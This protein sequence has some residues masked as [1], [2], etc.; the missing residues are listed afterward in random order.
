MKQTV[1]IAACML[2]YACSPVFASTILGG[3]GATFPH[4]LYKKLIAAYQAIEDVRITYDAV[5]SGEGIKRLMKRS[6]DFG[7][8]DA[9]LSEEERRSA[10]GPI[11]HIPAC[12]GAVAI[13]YNLPG[14]PELRFTPDVLA[15]IFLGNITVWNDGRIAALNAE[16]QLPELAITIVHRSDSSGTTFVFS[17]YLS[18]I[19]PAWRERCGC[20]KLIRW[21]VGVGLEG[22]SGVADFVKRIP[23]SISYVE[24]TYVE[25]NQLAA[26][27]LRNKSGRYVK[28]T[29]ESISAAADIH[30][31]ENACIMITDTSAPSGY[32]ISAFSY[33]IVYQQQRY[34]NRSLA[35]AQALIGFLWWV[36]HEG[37]QYNRLQLYAPLPV[38]AVKATERLLHTIYYGDRQLTDAVLTQ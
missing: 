6:V 33:L 2:A 3:A 36:I 22:S 14:R 23:G 18:R 28:P 15:D 11:V 32:P 25:T 8:T 21:Q 10:D 24:R 1:I 34:E 9:F 20:S 5:G 31:P 37:Q 16:L 35:Q 7:A 19:S 30:L 27:A 13:V 17:D 12:I 4:P 38:S 26:A 29:I